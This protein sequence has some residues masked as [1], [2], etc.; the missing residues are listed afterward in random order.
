MRVCRNLPCIALLVIGL[1]LASCTRPGPPPPLVAQGLSRPGELQLAKAERGSI[2]R[3]ITLAGTVV[4]ELTIIVSA[5]LAG[6]VAAV[7]VEP[8][9]AVTA[10]QKL[11]TLETGELQEHA[12]QAEVAWEAA[13][14]RYAQVQG[15]MDRWAR[16]GE[17]QVAAS[18]LVNWATEAQG[19][20]STLPAMYVPAFSELATQQ[21]QLAHMLQE[22]VMS[23]ASE[24]SA[25]SGEALEAAAAACRQAEAAY[26]AAMLLLS[27]AVITAPAAG[28]VSAVQVAPASVVAPGQ[29]LLS[30]VDEASLLVEVPIPQHELDRT[31]PGTRVWLSFRTG[32][33]IEAVVTSLS[34]VADIRTRAFSARVRSS[35]PWPATWRAGLLVEAKF[36]TERVDGVIIPS[37][38]VVTLQGQS[39]VYVWQNGAIQA[40]PVVLGLA[41]AGAVEIRQGLSEG[42]QV[43][44]GAREIRRFQV[45]R[46]GARTP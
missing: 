21:V 22:A 10:G 24:A 44:V 32:P 12:R 41:G 26:Q 18:S 33:S 45:I 25:A 13:R 6:Q 28:T 14:A 46:P 7:H 8:G 35:E 16:L 11:V 31:R 5:S 36:I 42:E 17:L 38:S 19:R 20:V 27:G 1:V 34:P 39:T 23:L 4:P 37:Q 2:E 29:P 9:Q 3:T 15:A 40:R 30:L 43:V